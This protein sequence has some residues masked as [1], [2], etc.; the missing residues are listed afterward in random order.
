M[1]DLH[2]VTPGQNDEEPLT[3]DAYNAA[4]R[5]VEKHR[6]RADKALRVLADV[7]DRD[8]CW[9]DHHGVCQAHGY[10]SLEQGEKCPQY[11]AK[12]LLAAEGVEV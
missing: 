11:E 1:N 10:L 7:V 6:E 2:I 5:A 8:D 9:L 3:W 4:S 12:E